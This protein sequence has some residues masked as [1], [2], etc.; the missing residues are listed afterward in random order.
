MLGA[1]LVWAVYTL[2]L[3]RRPR[4]LSQD[5]ALASSIVVALALMAP[6]L[7][8]QGGTEALNLSAPS[9]GAVLYIAVF[10]SLVAFLLWSSGVSEIGAAQ[11]GQF[12][13]LMPV[14]GSGLAVL[15]L[16]ESISA[17]QVI[18]SALVFAGIMLGQRAR[19]R[20]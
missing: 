5:V 2:L 7:V 13:Y 14:F 4:D 10:A 19:T 9:V 3:R 1:V 8:L 15:L 11:A 17:P 6:F 16:G 20:G 18:G 12:V